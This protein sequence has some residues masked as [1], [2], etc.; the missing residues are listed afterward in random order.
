MDETAQS[1]GAGEPA[2]LP[3]DSLESGMETGTGADDE[4]VLAIGDRE[5]TDDEETLSPHEA[6]RL[7]GGSE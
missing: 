1:D 7:L 3:E 4:P 2:S 6:T 5:Y